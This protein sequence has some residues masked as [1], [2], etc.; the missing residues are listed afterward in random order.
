MLLDRRATLALYDT[1]AGP[2]SYFVVTDEGTGLDAQPC[3]GNPQLSCS[4]QAG[5]HVVHWHHAGLLHALVGEEPMT[6]MSLARVCGAHA[7]MEEPS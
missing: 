7:S 3:T 1:A 2:A 4:T 6:L 5:Y